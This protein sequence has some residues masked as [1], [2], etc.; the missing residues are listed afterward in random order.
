M[1][2]S[3]RGI[4]AGLAAAALAPGLAQL[5]SPPGSVEVEPAAPARRRAAIKLA[6]S[7]GRRFPSKGKAGHPRKH[8]NM[9]HVSRRVRRKHRRGKA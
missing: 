4:F 3:Y 7:Q 1:S 6:R 2:L 9:N 5:S 8:R